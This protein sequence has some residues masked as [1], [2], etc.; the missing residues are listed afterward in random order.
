MIEE[1]LASLSKMIQPGAAISYLAVFLSGILISF[2]P[3]VYPLIPVT[4]AYIGAH[5]TSRKRG[6]MLS[7]FYVLG[8]AVMYSALGIAAALTGSL[9]GEI[10]SKAYASFIIG[11][12]CIILGMASAGIIKLRLPG[13]LTSSKFDVKKTTP[14]LFISFLIGLSSGLV[15]GPCTAPALGVV[16]TFVAAKQDL[17]FG[18][19]L[20]FVFALGMGLLLVLAGTFGGL[21]TTLPK[22]GAW[23]NRVQKFFGILL[24]IAGL[25]F[26]WQG[27][28]RL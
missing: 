10:A 18:A 4:I 14:N 19:S 5:T 23:M 15:I 16:L 9:F 22:A 13:F 26:I 17:F 20:M 12:V 24:L 6:F 27:I 21:L 28:G 2:T 1:L 7:L 8:I 11:A 3:C 25:F